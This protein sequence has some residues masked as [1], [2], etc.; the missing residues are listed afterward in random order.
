MFVD[1]Q[2]VVHVDH[3][4]DG[5]SFSHGGQVHHF[6]EFEKINEFFRDNTEFSTL[7]FICDGHKHYIHYAQNQIHYYFALWALRADI[8]EESG[9]SWVEEKNG[10]S[11]YFV[12]IKGSQ[13]PVFKEIKIGSS[14]DS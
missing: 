9:G 14:V 10:K 11:R 6:T 7:K 1:R 2:L 13:T 5:Y 8:S 12:A 4:Q 3:F